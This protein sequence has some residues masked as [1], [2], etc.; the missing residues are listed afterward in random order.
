MS[1]A[2]SGEPAPQV[3]AGYGAPA[4]GQVGETRNVA[5]SI[6]W[7]II[8]LGIY[9]YI[10]TFRTHREIQDYSGSGVGG[11]LG[12]IIYFVFSPITFFLIPSEIKNMLER[13]GRESPVT[14]WRGLWFLLP[15]IGAFF[16]FIPIQNALND[17]WMSKGATAP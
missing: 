7:A 4:R 12:F 14:A 3:Q 11:W 17:F 16:W 15:I 9:T 13:D 2:T 8:T 5:L 6:V 10:W 1:E